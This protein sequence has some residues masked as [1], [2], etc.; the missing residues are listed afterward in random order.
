MFSPPPPP[1]I[2]MLEDWD[3]DS[4]G[5]PPLEQSIDVDSGMASTSRNG[6]NSSDLAK[7]SFVAS[8]PRMGPQGIIVISD[9]EMEGGMGRVDGRGGVDEGIGMNEGGLRD[10]ICQLQRIW[11]RRGDGGNEGGMGDAVCQLKDVLGVIGQLYGDDARTNPNNVTVVYV[12]NGM[13]YGLVNRGHQENIGWGI[14]G[15]HDYAEGLN[16][17]ASTSRGTVN[18]RDVGVG[19][20]GMSA[21]VQRPPAEDG[22]V[23]G[24]V[25]NDGIGDAA[26]HGVEEMQDWRY[27]PVEEAESSEGMEDDH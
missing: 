23:G 13:V 11:R 9:D 25:A 21:G 6:S 22:G 15:G 7:T 27:V 4:S 26:D 12:R 18:G 17:G 8:P 16:V 3:S 10:G 5:P 20:S 24:N 19:G 1:P 2:P 14:G